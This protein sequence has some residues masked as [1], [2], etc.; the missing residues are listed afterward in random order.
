MY[1]YLYHN[2]LLSFQ[3]VSDRSF[4]H[5]LQQNPNPNPKALHT[6][7]NFKILNLKANELQ[8]GTVCIKE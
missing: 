1:T 8:R 7:T 6:K 5:V 3:H 2:T 4:K